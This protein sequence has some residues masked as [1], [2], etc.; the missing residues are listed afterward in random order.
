MYEEGRASSS[1]SGKDKDRR[2]FFTSI[3]PSASMMIVGSAGQL[4]SQ[5]I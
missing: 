1:I 2:V 5:R 4:G 3:S